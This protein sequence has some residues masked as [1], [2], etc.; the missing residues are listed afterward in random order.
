MKAQMFNIRF[1]SSEVKPEILKN[2]I[3]KIL[4]QSNFTI[5]EY[6]QKKFEPQGFSCVWLISESH[7]AVHTF[8][9]ENKSYIELSSCNLD[10]LLAFQKSILNSLTSCNLI[11][12]SF[13][14][15]SQDFNISLCTTL[16]SKIH[17]A[18]VTDS[19]LNYVGSIEI[20]ENLMQKANIKPN[21]QVHVVNLSNGNR[22]IT[23]A[24]PGKLNS[25]TISV[26]GGGARLAVKG[27]LL[28]I[29][30]Y[31]QI[32]ENLTIEPKLIILNKNNEELIANE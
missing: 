3:S 5:E 22:W 2:T 4:I 8:P 20:D 18:V 16:K 19:Q 1:W 17:R 26:N 6:N 27:D 28:I 10:K 9:E 24:L 32:P 30:A 15:I 14:P 25:K 7:C 12:T 29:M 23:Y 11:S 31:A 13:L 21:E